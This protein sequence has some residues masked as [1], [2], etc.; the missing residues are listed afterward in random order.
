MAQRNQTVTI[1]LEEYKELLLRDK[2][3]EQDKALL[4]RIIDII[5]DE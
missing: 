1:P 4:G 5:S 2:P 3:S